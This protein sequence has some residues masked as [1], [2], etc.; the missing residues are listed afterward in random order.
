MRAKQSEAPINSE[1]TETTR[2]MRPVN[3]GATTSTRMASSCGR[4]FKLASLQGRMRRVEE[5]HCMI[6]D[7][8]REGLNSRKYSDAITNSPTIVLDLVPILQSN[9]IFANRACR[10]PPTNLAVYRWRPTLKLVPA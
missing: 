5:A 10:L 1:S 7:T 6:E 9:T 2:M 4:D 3:S 8:K